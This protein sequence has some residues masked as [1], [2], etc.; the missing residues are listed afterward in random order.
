M[1]AEIKEV[2]PLILLKLPQDRFLN[3]SGRFTEVVK[4]V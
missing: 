3:P 4:S 2:Q 1:K